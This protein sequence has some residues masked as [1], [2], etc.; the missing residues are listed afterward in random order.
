MTLVFSEVKGGLISTNYVVKSILNT[1][2]PNFKVI[3]VESKYY[4][5]S[6]LSQV[7][8]EDKEENN[9]ASVH[10]SMYY[11]SKGKQMQF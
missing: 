5:C 6:Y 9:L 11:F 1:Y 2:Y 8:L 4:V 10:V 7:K 3:K